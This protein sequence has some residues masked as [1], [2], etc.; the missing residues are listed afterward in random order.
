MIQNFDIIFQ[1]ST[2]ING[3]PI[4]DPTFV[5]GHRLYEVRWPVPYL[6]AF[7]SPVFLPGSH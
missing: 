5:L 1:H 6:T 4:Y 3:S 2:Y 7:I